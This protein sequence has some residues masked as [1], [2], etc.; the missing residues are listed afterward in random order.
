M[1]RDLREIGVSGSIRIGHTAL[2]KINE[3]AVVL[4]RSNHNP[5]LQNTD[6]DHHLF[7]KKMNNRDFISDKATLHTKKEYPGEC[8]G[9]RMLFRIPDSNSKIFHSGSRIRI[10][11]FFIP[12][13]GSYR[14]L[15]NK[16]LTIKPT[17]FLFL[18][19]FRSI[20]NESKK[21]NRTAILK[22]S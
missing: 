17:I 10:P 4:G 16:R 21:N 14:Y 13:P 12:D 22:I 20:S 3:T 19:G 1:G 11:T 15:H 9:S 7:D 8:C 18:M 5:D 2:L 6:L